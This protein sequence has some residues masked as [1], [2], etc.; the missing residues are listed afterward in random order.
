M[1]P[2]RAAYHSPPSSAAGNEKLS[3]TTTHPLGHTEPVMGKFYL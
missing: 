2:E 3:Y 1:R